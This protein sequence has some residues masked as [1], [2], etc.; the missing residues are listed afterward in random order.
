[1]KKILLSLLIGFSS[2]WASIDFQNA[3]KE[4]LM[5]IKGIGEKKAE[6]IIEYRKTNPIKNMQDLDNVKGIGPALMA[7]IT[8]NV[9]SKR[10][11]Q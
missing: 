6:A 11:S 8:K 4:K 9:L 3:P 7:N 2:V 1:M 5:C 10:C